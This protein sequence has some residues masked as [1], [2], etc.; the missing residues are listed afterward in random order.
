MRLRMHRLVEV[1][2]HLVADHEALKKDYAE[3]EEAFAELKKL[4]EV[5]ASD[6]MRS[7]S[8]FP[9]SSIFGGLMH[10]R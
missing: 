3:L 8:N 5:L 1:Y 7:R 9:A 6:L 4:N 2:E 10:G